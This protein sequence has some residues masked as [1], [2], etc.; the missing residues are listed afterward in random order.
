[1]HFYCFFEIGPCFVAQAGLEFRIFLLSLLSVGIIGVYHHA[2]LSQFFV[3][4][5]GTFEE[6]AATVKFGKREFLAS[7]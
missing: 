2:Q 6:E 3:A 4:L 5:S 7:S 1:V